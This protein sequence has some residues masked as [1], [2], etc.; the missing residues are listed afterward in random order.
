LNEGKPKDYYSESRRRVQTRDAE[1]GAKVYNFLTSKG[2]SVFLSTFTLEQLGAADYTMEIDS[3]LESASVLLAIGTSADHLN[4]RWVR[5]ERDSFSNAI[6][7]RPKTE[8]MYICYIEGMSIA[9]WPWGL[10]LTQ[11]FVHA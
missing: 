1:I 8:S 2:L 7:K 10:Q 4:S 6:R 5:Y 9:D 3:A 11:T